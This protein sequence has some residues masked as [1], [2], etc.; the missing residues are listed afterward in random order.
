MRDPTILRQEVGIGRCTKS[1][2]VP[3]AAHF[4]TIPSPLV[5]DSGAQRAALSCPIRSLFVKRILTNGIERRPSRSY[6]P[7]RAS[8][9]TLRR[10]R[11]PTTDIRGRLQRPSN[12]IRVAR[13]GDSEP[14]PPEKRSNLLD[15]GFRE[16]RG[17]SSLL[18]RTTQYRSKYLY[19]ELE[20]FFVSWI[21]ADSGLIAA[22][23]VGVSS[24][25]DPSSQSIQLPRCL[26]RPC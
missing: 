6:S 5:P 22:D 2:R 10:Y 14:R 26:D 4:G 15:R 25:D 20:R 17:S 7:S 11:F 18:R 19:R 24:P 16:P 1:L 8:S 21:S 9:A 23:P 3:F 13:R 12:S